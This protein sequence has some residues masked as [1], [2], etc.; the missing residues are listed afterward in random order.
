MKKLFFILILVAPL[1]LKGQQFV[2]HKKIHILKMVDVFLPD[3][4]IEPLHFLFFGEGS[5]K[6]MIPKEK[7]EGNINVERT[8]FSGNRIYFSLC[9]GGSLIVQTEVG[10]NNTI[11]GDNSDKPIKK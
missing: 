1:F 4:V 5:I 8:I 9:G 2:N 11:K 6:I 3:T 10:E 7:Y